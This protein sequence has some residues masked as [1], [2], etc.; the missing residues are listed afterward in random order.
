MNLVQQIQFHKAFSRA[1]LPTHMVH[2]LIIIQTHTVLMHEAAT[3]VENIVSIT[4]TDKQTIW[5]HPST[6]AYALSLIMALV[7]GLDW[8]TFFDPPPSLSWGKLAFRSSEERASPPAQHGAHHR[9]ARQSR[10]E[11]LKKGETHNHP[12]TTTPPPWPP[13]DSNHYKI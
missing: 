2:S 1:C 7:I 13:F 3:R 10:V 9:S 12:S 6:H 8:C 4:Q 11:K 5:K